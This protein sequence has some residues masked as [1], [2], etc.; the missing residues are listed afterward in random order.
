MSDMPESTK[1]VFNE[2]KN[3]ILWLHARWKIYRQLFAHS[4]RRVDLL[5][6]SARVF[7]IIVHATLL[8]E[9]QI[10]FGKLTD[11]ARTGK[12]EN[13]SLDQ[14]QER[15]EGL[16]DT[17]FSARLRKMLDGIHDK[18][19][20]FRIR[21]NKRLAHFDLDTSLQLEGEPLPGVSRQM[22]EDALSLIRKYMNTI[23]IHYIQTETGY[24][25]VTMSGNDGDALVAWLKDGLD[26]SDLARKLKKGRTE[27]RSGKWND[28]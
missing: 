7:F 23:G 6:R 21:R 12:H 19:R 28:A 2:L 13:L 16:D 18:C 26:F 22:I 8:D 4:A 14:L 10:S 17:D 9:I 27:L 5:N 11:P 24:E 25:R 1:D 3:E 20:V 15:V